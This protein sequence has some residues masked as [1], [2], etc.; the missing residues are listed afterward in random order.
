M[1]ESKTDIRCCK[2]FVEQFT[3][4]QTIATS[5]VH[6]SWTNAFQ[7][8]S[9]LFISLRK[10]CCFIQSAMRRK[11]QMSTLG[12]ENIFFYVCTKTCDEITFFFQHNGIENNAIAN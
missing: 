12:N 8:R 10:L 3:Y 11:N 1:F 4:T 5:L 2:I 7:C 9:D 6:V